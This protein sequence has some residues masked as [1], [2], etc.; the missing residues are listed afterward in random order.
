MET[1]AGGEGI[2]IS[3]MQEQEP[4][5]DEDALDEDQVVNKTT[6]EMKRGSVL[7]GANDDGMSEANLPK[8]NC[9]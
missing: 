6:E 3:K 2:S 8:S 1:G 7:N 9:M 4:M 5:F